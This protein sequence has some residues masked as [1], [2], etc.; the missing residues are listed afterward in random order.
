MI[1]WVDL[2]T[3]GLD[4]DSDAVLEVAAIATD[5]ALVEVARFHAVTD[6]A[7]YQ[8]LACLH[9]KVQEM[10]TRSGLWERSLAS[11]LSTSDVAADLLSWIRNSGAIGAQLAGSTVS[12]DRAFL[13]ACMPAVDQALHYRNLD[14]T[15][16]NEVARRFWP[17]VH[18]G[19]PR[20]GENQHQ[21][22]ADIEHSVA[23]LRY[24]LNELRPAGER[25]ARFAIRV[26]PVDAHHVRV[27]GDGQV[28]TLRAGDRVE[29]TIAPKMSADVPVLA[30]LEVPE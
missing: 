25:A 11:E 23:V 29:F 27:T 5:D 15:T 18:E 1:V 6:E 16:L 4:P 3:T 10:H 7:K 12:F 19:V 8:S 9:P 24:Y 22:V 14:V 21:A 17:E 28:R 26:E 2:E 30:V 13:R 20:G